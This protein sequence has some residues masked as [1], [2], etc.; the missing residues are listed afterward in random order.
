MLLV[1][2]HLSAGDGEPS[3]GLSVGIVWTS[4]VLPPPIAL[5]MRV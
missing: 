3:S 1:C 4:S 2:K 5:L